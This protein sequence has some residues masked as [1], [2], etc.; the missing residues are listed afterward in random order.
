MY[1]PCIDKDWEQIARALAVEW[2]A[3]ELKVQAQKMNLKSVSIIKNQTSKHD[4]LDKIKKLTP[5]G[6]VPKK[7]TIQREEL[8]EVVMQQLFVQRTENNE[9]VPKSLD[10]S[11]DEVRFLGNFRINVN[12]GV[13]VHRRSY[14]GSC[15]RR[16]LACAQVIQPFI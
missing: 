15:F 8:E 6:R 14:A 2:T 9:N 7:G 4:A 16:Q 10:D 13:L 1:N 3:D 12:I 11:D 5:K